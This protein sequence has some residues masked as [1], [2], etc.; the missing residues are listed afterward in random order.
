MMDGTEPTPGFHYS[1][2]SVEGRLLG[3]FTHRL[4]AVLERR[5][6]NR[7]LE[8]KL[9][10]IKRRAVEPSSPE[11]APPGDLGSTSPDQESRDT[12]WTTAAAIVATANEVRNEIVHSAET[13]ADEIRTAARKRAEQL[14]AEAVLEAGEIRAAARG[15]TVRGAGGRP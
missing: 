14:V 12:A 5:I 10:E 11:D 9:S 13:E 6:S 3:E 15:R 4:D 7:R 1:E 8:Q 2:H